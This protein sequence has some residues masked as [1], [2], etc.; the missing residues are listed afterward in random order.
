MK[1]LKVRHIKNSFFLQ[2][3]QQDC[4]IACLLSVMQYFH[5]P[6]EYEIL[7]ERADLKTWGTSMLD[8][9]KCADLSGFRAEAFEMDM[10]NLQARKSP[11][12]LHVINREGLPHFIICYRYNKEN[13]FLIGDPA[14]GVMEVTS[15]ALLELWKSRCALI[16]TPLS[17]TERDKKVSG[18]WK[19]LL[20][21]VAYEKFLLILITF[22]GILTAIMGLSLA[23]YLQVFT[24]RILPA[25]NYTHL[26]TTLTIVILLFT[27]R[28][29]VI[30]YRQQIIIAMM[31]DF[32]TKLTQAFSRHLLKL[33]LSYLRRK[34][35]GDMVV[36]F[37]DTQKV[38]IAFSTAVTLILVDLVMLVAVTGFVFFYSVPVALLIILFICITTLSGF[39]NSSALKTQQQ[40]L[41]SDF[42][43][44]DN[45]LIDII[46]DFQTVQG[47]NEPGCI[48]GM[49][50]SGFFNFIAS[51]EKFSNRIRNLSF[52]YDMLGTF[53]FS[54]ILVYTSWL[55]IDSQY[56]K[57]QFLALITLIS[58]IF[59]V[60]QRICITGM[61]LMDGVISLERVYSM[62]LAAS[63]NTTS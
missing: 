63:R 38:Q 42:C 28:C 9:K 52:S 7:C 18:K 50:A 34:T 8:L 37:N 58:G 48:A 35:T 44:T 62:I 40:K 55:V 13:S 39:F 30:R 51:S 53:F 6:G 41:T 31:K 2:L 26:V 25:K 47:K 14:S 61:I 19:W 43:H 5:I 15:A 45:M 16:L 22:L 12:I 1:W 27:A 4:G 29:F 54:V 60:V 24:D 3:D 11:V 32:N 23:I 57:G 59:P 10:A 46:K 20:S 17:G 21:L 49:E 36:R 33:P 56:S